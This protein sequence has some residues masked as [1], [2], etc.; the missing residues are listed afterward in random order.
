MLLVTAEYDS[1]E[2]EGPPHSVPAGEVDRLYPEAERT[3]LERYEQDRNDG[4][5]TTFTIVVHSLIRPAR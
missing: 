2:R 4:D 3:E 1:A 5:L